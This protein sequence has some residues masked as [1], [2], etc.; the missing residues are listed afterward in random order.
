MEQLA[1]CE[2]CGR[3]ETIDHALFNY[4]WAYN[5]FWKEVYKLAAVKIPELRSDFWPVYL[6]AGKMVPD[7]DTTVILCGSW[8]LSGRNARPLKPVAR[9]LSK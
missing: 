3:D 7:K 6:G 4:K 8:R 1:F 5:M 2:D 9:P